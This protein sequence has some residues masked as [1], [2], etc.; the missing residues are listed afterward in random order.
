MSIEI[1][2]L[3]TDLCDYFREWIDSRYV[4]E[5]AHKVEGDAIHVVFEDGRRI[6][7]TAEVLDG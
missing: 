7:I 5:R 4:V 3:L 1:D 2:E 6:Q